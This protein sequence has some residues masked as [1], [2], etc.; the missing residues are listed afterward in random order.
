MRACVARTASLARD[1]R[2]SQEGRHIPVNEAPHVFWKYEPTLEGTSPAKSLL[3][4][5]YAALT[6]LEQVTLEGRLGSEPPLTRFVP[7][8]SMFAMERL[9]V[10]PW[11]PVRNSVTQ[12]S[13]F[14][15]VLRGRRMP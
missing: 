13:L 5:V 3:T 7:K 9:P 4:M 12:S 14:C 6:Q 10:V 2:H 8:A 15:F 11:T 1:N